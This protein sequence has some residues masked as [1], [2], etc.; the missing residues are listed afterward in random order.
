MK[1]LAVVLEAIFVAAKLAGVINWSWWLVLAPI[2]VY[3]GLVVVLLIFLIILSI[4]LTWLGKG[5]RMPE[6][7]YLVRCDEEDFI[8]A[9]DLR[10]DAERACEDY[11][12]SSAYRYYVDECEFFD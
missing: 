12:A 6:I 1:L 4:V 9:Y 10:E 7:I 11:Q 2:W 8:Q 5:W 3:I